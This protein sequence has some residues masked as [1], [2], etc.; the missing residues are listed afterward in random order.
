MYGAFYCKTVLEWNFSPPPKYVVYFY[1]KTSF[2]PTLIDLL[3]RFLRIGWLKV[4]TA[5]LTCIFA[6]K[7][8]RPKCHALGRK[9]SYSLCYHT[10]LYLLEITVWIKHLRT[11]T[12]LSE[13]NLRSYKMLFTTKKLFVRMLR[14]ILFS[15]SYASFWANATELKVK[16]RCLIASFV[17]MSGC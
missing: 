11:F 14:I 8:W 4:F 7:K 10:K 6:L 17:C 15:A 12:T 16:R 13:E 1:L 9:A 2:I 5:L 3:V